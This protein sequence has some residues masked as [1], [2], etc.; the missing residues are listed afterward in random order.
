ML[1][2]IEEKEKYNPIKFK[3]AMM[4]AVETWIIIMI[5][6]MIIYCLNDKHLNSVF[7]LKATLEEFK[8]QNHQ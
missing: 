5:L 6:T 4:F 2:Q 1:E 3:Q 7:G 8:Y